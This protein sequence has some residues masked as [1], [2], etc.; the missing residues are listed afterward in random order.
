MQ[1]SYVGDETAKFPDS[2]EL[3]LMSLLAMPKEASRPQ[4]W[5]MGSSSNCTSKNLMFYRFLLISIIE[6]LK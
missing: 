2:G 4:T 1:V 6:V 3:F 5:R